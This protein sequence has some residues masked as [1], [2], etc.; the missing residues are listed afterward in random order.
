MTRA[1]LKGA[2]V[3]RMQEVADGSGVPYSTLRKIVDGRT[4]S[5]QYDTIKALAKWYTEN[6]IKVETGAPT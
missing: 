4:Q 3:A 6:P 2:P 1:D 5:P